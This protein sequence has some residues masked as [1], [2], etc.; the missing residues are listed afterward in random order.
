MFH[1]FM[2]RI[3]VVKNTE[4]EKIETRIY[5]GAD[6]SPSNSCKSGPGFCCSQ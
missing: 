3:F 5:Y 6:F 1:N 2:K 4:K